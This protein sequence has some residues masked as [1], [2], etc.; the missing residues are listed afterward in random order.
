M[1]NQLVFRVDGG[2]HIGTGHVMRCLTLADYWKE[3]GGTALFYMSQSTEALDERIAQRG[4]SKGQISALAGS[5]GD[6]LETAQ[7]AKA[8]GAS[9]IAADGYHFGTEWQ[10]AAIDSGAKLLFFDDFGHTKHYVAHL[11]LNQNLH[12]REDLYKSRAAWTRLLIGN[13]YLLLGQQ[14]LSW[15]TWGRTYP[16]V[17]K[18]VLVTFGGS[19]PQN[20]TS[21][22]V[23]AFE[24]VQERDYDLRIIVGGSNPRALEVENLAAGCSQSCDVLR[25]VKDMAT[26]MA[27]ADWAVMGG[28]TTCWEAAFMQLPALAISCAHQEDLLLDTLSSYGLLRKLGNI[29]DCTPPALTLA[30]SKIARDRAIRESMGKKGRELLDGKGASRVIDALRELSQC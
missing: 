10:E 18:K 3:R 11:V 29:K 7:Q 9:L 4:Y 2:I 14:F 15:A 5:R 22:V 26:H 12:A 27:W 23:R 21:F 28:G 16:L 8:A 30:L 25:D 6:A 17:G 13:R 19:D 1:S 20:I 24:Q